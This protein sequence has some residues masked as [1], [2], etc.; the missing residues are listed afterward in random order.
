MT[1]SSSLGFCQDAGRDQ[2]NCALVGNTHIQVSPAI[3]GGDQQ[4]GRKSGPSTPNVPE[5]IRVFPLQSAVVG[6]QKV[7]ERV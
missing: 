3:C 7:K 6:R 1:R 5:I 4:T 2:N